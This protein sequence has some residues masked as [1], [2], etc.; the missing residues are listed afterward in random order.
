M[1]KQDL[2][3]PAELAREARARAATYYRR[4]RAATT[5]VAEMARERDAA[6]KAADAA[7][8]QATAERDPALR[9]LYRDMADDYATLALAYRRLSI[10]AAEEA[11]LM[12]RL[13]AAAMAEARSIERQAA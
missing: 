7:H 3:G 11:P 2:L 4:G 12:R 1:S 10:K 8:E 13:G 5:R 9:K 6:G